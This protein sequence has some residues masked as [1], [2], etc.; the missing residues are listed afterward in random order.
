[1]TLELVKKK[2]ICPRNT[3]KDTKIFRNKRQAVKAAGLSR[4]ELIAP[5]SFALFERFVG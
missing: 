1:M 5:S 3:R 4:F 2:S